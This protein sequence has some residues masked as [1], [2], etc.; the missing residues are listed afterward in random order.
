MPKPLPAGVGPRAAE[1]C[2]PF[3]RRVRRCYRVVR[4]VQ[5]CVDGFVFQATWVTSRSG[6]P[7]GQKIGLNFLLWSGQ[8][9]WGGNPSNKSI[10]APPCQW[11]LISVVRGESSCHQVLGALGAQ[12]WVVLILY[13]QVRNS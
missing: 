11:L 4:G 9:H 7:S 10:A 12:I 13:A 5:R 6:D 1:C 2:C 3:G 8:H